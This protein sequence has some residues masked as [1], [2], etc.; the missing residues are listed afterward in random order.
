MIDAT[1]KNKTNVLIFNCGPN[2]VSNFTIFGWKFGGDNTKGNISGSCEI[3]SYWNTPTTNKKMGLIII[4]TNLS[5]REQA[6]L[7]Q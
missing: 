3:R 7:M 1:L 2:H 4:N 5:Q 6:C